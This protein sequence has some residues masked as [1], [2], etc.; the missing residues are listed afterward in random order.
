MVSYQVLSCCFENTESSGEEA[1]E[2]VMPVLLQTHVCPTHLSATSVDPLFS[3]F[4][5]PQ[6]SPLPS[7][8]VCHFVPNGLLVPCS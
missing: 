2:W 7:A 4:M 1:G 3:P 8:S 6:Q 5:Q